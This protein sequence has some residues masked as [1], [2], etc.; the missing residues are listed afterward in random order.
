MVPHGQM[1]PAA[2]FPEFHHIGH[3]TEE[4]RYYPS[5]LSDANIG[6]RVRQLAANGLTPS[7]IA[8]ALEIAPVA[9]N[10]Y[11]RAAAASQPAPKPVSFI[12]ITPEPPKTTDPE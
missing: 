8:L 3:S 12:D 10:S 7:L 11:L 1:P 2:G 9:V 6:R 5:M 4:L